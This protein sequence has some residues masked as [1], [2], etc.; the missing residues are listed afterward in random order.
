M[1]SIHSFQP[2]RG[3]I[4]AARLSAIVTDGQ[5]RSYIYI[6]STNGDAQGSPQAFPLEKPVEPMSSVVVVPY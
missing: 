2:L 1:Q 5:Y 4:A 6:F 3:V